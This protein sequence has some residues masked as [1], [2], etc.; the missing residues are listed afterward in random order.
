VLNT[1]YEYNTNILHPDTKS[2][3]TVQK[4]LDLFSE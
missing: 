4:F 3:R 2:K 1:K